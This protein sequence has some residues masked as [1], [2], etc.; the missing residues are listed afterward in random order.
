MYL[1]PIF[2]CAQ[3]IKARK[4]L[5]SFRVTMSASGAVTK[6]M[7]CSVLGVVFFFLD[8]KKKKKDDALILPVVE[9]EGV[10]QI[11]VI[12]SYPMILHQFSLPEDWIYY[13]CRYKYLEYRHPL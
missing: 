11:I 8:I 10:I 4:A 1:L 9:D 12:I 3:A 13:K 7:T 5:N 2:F 6:R